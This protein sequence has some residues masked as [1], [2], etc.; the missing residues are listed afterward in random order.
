MHFPRL[1]QGMVLVLALLVLAIAGCSRLSQE[2]YNKLKMGMTY[3]EVVGV[4]GSPATCDAAMGAK[5]CIWGNEQKHIKI[6]FVAD[7]VVIFTCK[8]L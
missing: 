6:N 1:M 4:L 3:E 7:R 8:G 2:S 5:S